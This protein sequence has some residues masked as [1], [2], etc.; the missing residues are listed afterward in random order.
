V[1]EK[2]PAVN[3]DGVRVKSSGK[4]DCPFYFTLEES[5]SGWVVSHM[6]KDAMALETF[7]NH[8]L[9][10]SRPAAN[11]ALGGALRK[12]PVDLMEMGRFMSKH[13]TQPG[14]IYAALAREC[15]ERGYEVTFTMSDV[16]NQF[17]ASTLERVLDATGLVEMLEKRK[18]LQGLQYDHVT[19][20]E[21]GLTRV[22]FEFKGGRELWERS[23]GKVVILDSKH[24]TQRYG[25]KLT[26]LVTVD[27]NGVTQVLAA[28]LLRHEDAE[29]FKWVLGSRCTLPRRARSGVKC[30]ANTN[31]PT[32]A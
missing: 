9:K 25:L 21:D 20:G 1:E 15:Q 10:T 32:G 14:K 2:K 22:F 30:D 27:R 3:P 26:C 16:R 23:G 4:C 24:G 5:H 12:I 17:A 28:S 8:R 11:A 29:S 31:W 13:N 19:E 6:H 7:H 18:V